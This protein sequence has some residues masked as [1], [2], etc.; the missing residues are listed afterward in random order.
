MPKGP[1]IPHQFQKQTVFLTDFTGFLKG[2]RT[3]LLEAAEVALNVRDVDLKVPSYDVGIVFHGLRI[4]WD[5]RPDGFETGF[6]VTCSRNEQK[7][8]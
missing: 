5:V 7:N 8:D 3:L 1:S 6:C 4:T 2:P